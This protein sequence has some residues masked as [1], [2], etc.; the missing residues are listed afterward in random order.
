MNTNISSRFP[1]TICA[2]RTLELQTEDYKR[3]QNKN[4]I[5]TQ[6]T[7][8]SKYISMDGKKNFHVLL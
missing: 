2:E 1:K 8:M 4:N 7:Y 5:K 3:F 6:L